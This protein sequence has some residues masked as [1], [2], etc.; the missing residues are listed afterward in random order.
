MKLKLNFISNMKS[1]KKKEQTDVGVW[2]CKDCGKFHI[3]SE[4]HLLTFTREEFSDFV[5]KTWDCFYE[6]A[7]DLSAVNQIYT[8]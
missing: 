2:R 4:K 6:Q 1:N 8:K 3:K 7:F 5:N